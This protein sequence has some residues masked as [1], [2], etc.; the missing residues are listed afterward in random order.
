[1]EVFA[2]KSIISASYGRLTVELTLLVGILPIFAGVVNECR[3]FEWC[4]MLESE[5]AIASGLLVN[6]G[7]VE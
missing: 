2:V 4:F 7:L 5:I 3:V 1:M 6:E